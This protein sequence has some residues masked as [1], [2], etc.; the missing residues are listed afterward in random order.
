MAQDITIKLLNAIDSF[1][2]WRSHVMLG[3]NNFKIKEVE[4]ILN[5]DRKIINQV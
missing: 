5:E 4:E 1:I 3:N 2:S